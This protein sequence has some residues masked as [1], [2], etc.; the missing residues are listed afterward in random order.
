MKILLD[1]VEVPWP[2]CIEVRVDPQGESVRGVEVLI[3]GGK[4]HVLPDLPTGANLLGRSSLSIVGLGNVVL[5][6]PRVDQWQ[7]PGLVKA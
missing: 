2:R 3:T 6:F 5:G 1:G 4:L 7:S